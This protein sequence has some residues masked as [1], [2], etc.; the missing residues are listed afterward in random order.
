M[1]LHAQDQEIITSYIRTCAEHIFSRKPAPTTT[2]PLLKSTFGIRIYAYEHNE[3]LFSLFRLAKETMS[4]HEQIAAI[5]RSIPSEAQL[6]LIREL[7]SVSFTFELLEPLQKIAIVSPTSFTESDGLYFE[8]L[9][10]RSTL[11]PEEFG[12]DSIQT[13]ENLCVKASLP[14]DFWQQIK[15]DFFK[16][17]VHTFAQQ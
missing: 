8:Y 4:L 14:K 3:L 13:R 10:F 15:G 7:D 17:R 1:E 6:Q 2:D 12:R 16:F 11:F 5:L 9:S